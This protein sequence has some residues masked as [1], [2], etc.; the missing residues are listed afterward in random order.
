MAT[1]ARC[2]RPKTY[3]EGSACFPDLSDRICLYS[4]SGLRPSASYRKIL[5]PPCLVHVEPPMNRVRVLVPG[6]IIAGT[7][8][9][10]T[11]PLNPPPLVG[12]SCG[13]RSQVIGNRRNLLLG[14][15]QPQAGIISCSSRDSQEYFDENRTG[16]SYW[17]SILVEPK[18]TISP[19]SVRLPVDWL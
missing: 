2:A 6:R 4:A 7:E 18:A 13:A 14:S 12:Y 19:R 15:R 5:K 9:R 8:G 11:R 16:W 17:Y 3:A 1:G 10:G